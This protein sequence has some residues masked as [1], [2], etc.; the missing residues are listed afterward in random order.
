MKNLALHKEAWQSST[1]WAGLASRAVDGNH[2]TNH[3]N[4][5][6]CTHTDEDETPWFLVDLESTYEVT[7][8]VITNRGDDYSKL[9]YVSIF[10]PPPCRTLQADSLTPGRPPSRNTPSRQTSPSRQNPL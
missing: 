7:H 10:V 2:N 1:G 6:H 5:G 8:V 3:H 4:T 9:I